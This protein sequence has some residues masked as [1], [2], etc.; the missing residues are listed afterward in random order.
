MRDKFAILLAQGSP[1]SLRRAAVSAGGTTPNVLVGVGRRAGS[2]ADVSTSFDDAQLAIQTLRR[3]G[4][5]AGFMSYEDFDFATRLFSDVGSARMTRWAH[6][7]LRPLQ[8]REPLLEGLRQF[9]EHDQNMNAA[10]DALSIHHNSLRYRLAKVE[11]LLRINLRDPGAIASVFL[12]L[13]ALDLEQVNAQSPVGVRAN[14]QPVDIEAPR[15][16][17]DAVTPKLDANLGVVF[18]PDRR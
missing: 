18:G 4:R 12:A 11:E 16:V 7:F 1:A 14:V 8:D 17:R 13:A 3:S 10:S 2:V 6:E 15:S 5:R 9:F